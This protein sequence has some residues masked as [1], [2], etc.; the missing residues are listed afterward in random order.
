M[1]EGVTIVQYL[2]DLKPEA[3][4]APPASS[5][6][7]YR[8]QSWLT[9][10]SS[11]LHKMFSPW[12]FHPEYGAQAQEAARARIAER[13]AYVE[14]HLAAAGPFLMGERLTAADAYLYTIVGWSG[15]AKV[16]LT[17][18]PALRGYMDRVGRRPQVREAIA[19]EKAESVA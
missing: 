12:L 18:F 4:L 16:D 3:G 7:R 5:R 17:A 15:F 14:R 6:E 10:I 11:E 2:A 1:T 9:F 19:A 13:L 8:L